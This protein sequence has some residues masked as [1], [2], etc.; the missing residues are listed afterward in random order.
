MRAEPSVVS[1]DVNC[2]ATRSYASP[3]TTPGKS[4]LRL[5]EGLWHFLSNRLFSDREG[6]ADGHQARSA[7][8]PRV[9]G[10]PSRVANA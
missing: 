1:D 4:P 2:R 3:P 6:V 5:T 9:S 10:K 7:A 8:S